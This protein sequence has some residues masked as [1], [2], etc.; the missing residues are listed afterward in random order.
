MGSG[1]S[2]GRRD[3]MISVRVDAEVED[4]I[5]REAE[6]RGESLSSFVR[7]T[8]LSAVEPTPRP[9]AP[10]WGTPMTA[11]TT[12]GAE[13]GVSDDGRIYTRA[14]PYRNPLSSTATATG[15]TS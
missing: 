12:V 5:R 2:D 4:A 11:T 3:G 9:A 13:I 15:T 7:R 10:V 14:R 8:L 6:A 1:K